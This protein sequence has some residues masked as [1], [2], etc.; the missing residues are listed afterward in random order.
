MM[1][2]GLFQSLVLAGILASGFLVVWA[3]VAV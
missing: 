2:K 3:V 1:R